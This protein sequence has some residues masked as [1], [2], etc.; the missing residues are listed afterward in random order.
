MNKTR[1][2]GRLREISNH[3]IP[4][5]SSTF[6]EADSPTLLLV[7]PEGGIVGTSLCITQERQH[8][9]ILDGSVVVTYVISDSR[10]LGLDISS[11]GTPYEGATSH[12]PKY[13]LLTISLP[14]SMLKGISIPDF[15]AAVYALFTL[16]HDQEHIPIIL[17]LV[18]NVDE[19]NQYLLSTGLAR[20]HV[21]PDARK[22]KSDNDVLFLSRAAFWQGAGTVGYHRRSWLRNPQPPFP[23]IP[24]FTRNEKVIA[25]HPLR[26]KKPEQGEVLYRRWCSA[27]N[28]MLELRYFDLDGVHDE[29]E[30]GS[31]PTKSSRHM[32]AFHRWHNDERVN[33]AWGERGSL[34]T[35]RGYVEAVLADPHV[36]PCMLSWDG[37]LMG[38]VEIV[39]VKENHVAQY[40][41]AG[42]VPG[43]WER[44]VHVLVGEDKFLGGGRS[45]IW[46]RS[47]VH[48]LFLAD[49]R[50][51]RVAGEPRE[52]NEAIFK[53][54][55]HSGFHWQTTFDFPYKRSALLLNPREKFF[56]LCHLR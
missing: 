25:M 1:L 42:V 51:D 47:L 36:L 31:N 24:S 34:E 28:Q 53:V 29:T 54:A 26:P 22:F 10:L 39:Y 55:L 56:N 23:N 43:D 19:I 3:I 17:T 33:S 2:V 14:D 18:S 35:H 48:Y 20:T 44:G 30:T 27:V 7:L 12:I 13:K 50:T 16:Y 5:S 37:E 8:R 21:R 46:L 11:V 41:P 15:W 45:E 52:S 40:Y 38:Y 32:E 9:I 49:P 4:S 6:S